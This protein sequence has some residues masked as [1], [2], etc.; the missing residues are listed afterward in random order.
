MIVG[1]W[2]GSLLSKDNESIATG[3]IE[4]LVVTVIFDN[5]LFEQGLVTEWG[6]SA[7]ISGAE[8]TILFDTGGSD[9]LLSNMGK[10]NIRPES[11]NVVVLSHKHP[12]HTGGLMSL[13]GR[14]GNLSV[15][16]PASFGKELKDGIHNF[17]VTVVEVGE[18]VE[19]CRDVY[20]TG[21]IGT[22]IK[23]QA[24]VIRSEKGL[25]VIVGCAHPGIVK[26]VRAAKD[27]VKEEVLLV[28]GGFHLEWSSKSRIKKIISAFERL[29]VR[30]VAPTH[31]SGEKARGLFCERFGGNYIHAGAGKTIRVTDL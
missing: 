7:V 3:G 9:I 2:K 1:P 4:N 30:Y 29:G 21:Q 22:L 10:L 11:L 13:L 28:V 18:P 14:R 31:C 19:I 20:S 16:V 6:F 23:E 25:V 26:I 24:L 15:Y 8:K 17:G 5:N 27:L 12:D